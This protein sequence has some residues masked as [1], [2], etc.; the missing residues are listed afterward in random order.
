MITIREDGTFECQTAQ[1]AVAVMHEL[2]NGGGHGHKNGN[3]APEET[4]PLNMNPKLAQALTIIAT[5]Q[6]VTRKSLAKELGVKPIA[7]NAVIGRSLAH[8]LK[9]N[10]VKYSTKDLV[11]GKNNTY[12]GSD[13]LRQLMRV[14]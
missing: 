1:E 5:Q 12:Y 2:R 7:L 11:V 4:H 6:Q 8:W 10:K 13:K 3:T 9:N 14:S